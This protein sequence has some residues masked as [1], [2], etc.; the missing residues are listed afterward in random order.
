MKKTFVTTC[1]FALIGMLPL[2]AQ[3][4]EPIKF[5]TELK[6]ISDTEAELVFNATIDAGWH[7]YSTD[8]PEDGPISATINFDKMEGAE[9]VGKL[10]PQGK[11]VEH[12]DNMFEMKLRY[13]ENKGSFVQKVKFTGGAYALKGY[14][15]YGACNDENCLPPTDVEFNYTGEVKGAAS[16]ATTKAETDTQVH[17]EPLPVVETATAGTPAT[18]GTSVNTLWTPVIDEMNALLADADALVKEYKET[19]EDWL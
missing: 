10:T 6:K 12:F 14:L 15:Q 9:L 7:L 5:R 18:D 19:H 1:L 16:A 8:L 17:T 3:I 11:V 2:L 13:F 4:Q